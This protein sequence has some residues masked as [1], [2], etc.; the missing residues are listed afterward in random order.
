VTLI[1]EHLE[2]YIESFYNENDTYTESDDTTSSDEEEDKDD[3][4][5]APA[6]IKVSTIKQSNS[7]RPVTNA[8]NK[9]MKFL[10]SS[11]ALEDEENK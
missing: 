1:V 5:L 11:T 2:K 7:L 8:L 9:K 3:Q 4:Y 6:R 10:K